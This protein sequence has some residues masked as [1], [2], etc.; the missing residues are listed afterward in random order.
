MV[1][2]D[3]I[4]GCNCSHVLLVKMTFVFHLHKATVEQKHHRRDETN[5]ML[6]NA[7]EMTNFSITLHVYHFHFRKRNVPWDRSWWD[8]L[9]DCARGYGKRKGEHQH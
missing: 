3:L 6:C 7:K 2:F 1:V 4:N 8:Q 9:P 5:H